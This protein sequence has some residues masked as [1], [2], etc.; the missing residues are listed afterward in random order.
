MQTSRSLGAPIQNCVNWGR[1]S[2]GGALATTRGRI[3]QGRVARGGCKA[4]ICS[5][6]CDQE[7]GPGLRCL[8]QILGFTQAF[9]VTT[10]PGGPSIKESRSATPISQKIPCLPTLDNT[11]KW[12]YGYILAS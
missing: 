5:D 1:G 12:P 9:T 7:L 8:V 10:I 2:G 11:L 6:P 3:A 4:N